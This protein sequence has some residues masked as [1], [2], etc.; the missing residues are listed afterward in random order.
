MKNRYS[1][2]RYAGVATIAIAGHGHE[3]HAAEQ[4]IIQMIQLHTATLHYRPTR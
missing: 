2:N 3:A 1:Y 4:D